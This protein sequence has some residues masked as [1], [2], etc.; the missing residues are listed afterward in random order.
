MR[1]YGDA[2]NVQWTSFKLAISKVMMIEVLGT[3]VHQPCSMALST[4]SG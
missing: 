1:R 2:D 4:F 3:L